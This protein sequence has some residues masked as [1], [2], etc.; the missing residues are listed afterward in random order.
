MNNTSKLGTKSIPK[1]MI[2]LSVP[3]IV[4]QLINMLYNLVDRMYIGRIEGVGTQA[5]TGLGLAFPIIMIVSAFGA[6]AGMGGAPLAAIELGKGNKEKAEKILGNAIIL[7]G[8]FSLSLTALFYTFQ[9]PLLYLF[10]ASDVTIVYAMEYLSIYLFGTIFVQASLGLNPYISTQGRSTIAMLSILIGAITNIILDPILIFWFDMGVSGAAL[11]TII[12]QALSSVWIVRFLCSEKSTLRITK[13]IV[14]FDMGVIQKIGALGISPFI[15]QS[16][17]SLVNI[18]FSSTLQRYGGDLYVGTITVLTSIMQLIVVPM[19]GFTSGVQPIISYNYGAGNYDRVRTT[20]KY[21]LGAAFILSFCAALFAISNPEIFAKIFTEDQELINLISEVLPIFF[22]GT[23]IFG[24]QMAAQ[25]T[26]VGLGFAK[27]SLFIA[28][29][30]KIILLIPFIFILASQFGVMGVYYAEP[31]ADSLSAI[32]SGVF[33][34][35]V[36]KRVLSNRPSQI[37]N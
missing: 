7:I 11:A 27:I 16:T 23:M 21:M 20:V 28:C 5:L 25:S 22:I 1:L 12:S 8:F 19:N 17:E 6:F 37:Q 14:K 13:N 18:V 4:A 9:E 31:L 30:R 15:M 3:M 35:V 33:L 24:I 36:Y 26:F 10:G 34:F 32:T 2:E 29:L